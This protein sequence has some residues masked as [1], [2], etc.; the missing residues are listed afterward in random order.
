MA[1]SNPSKE[2]IGGPILGNNLFSNTY[3]IEK[4]HPTVKE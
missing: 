1:F 2:L 3:I 4:A